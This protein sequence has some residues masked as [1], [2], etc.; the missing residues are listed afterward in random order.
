MD[1]DMCE[2]FC[3]MTAVARVGTDAGANS[4]MQALP[5]LLAPWNM[6]LLQ[7]A[8]LNKLRKNDVRRPIHVA[9]ERLTPAVCAI[10]ITDGRWVIN[11]LFNV[12]SNAAGDFHIRTARDVSWHHAP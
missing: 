7:Q 10:E 11:A 8:K 5:Y 12:T 2:P 9:W 6:P 1:N 3:N 4:L